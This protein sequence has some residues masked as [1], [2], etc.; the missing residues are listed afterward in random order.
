MPFRQTRVLTHR[1]AVGAAVVVVLAS[2]KLG[3]QSRPALLDKVSVEV[4]AVAESS[5]YLV[6]RYRIV[7]PA[8]N[9]AGVAL[10]SI[11]VSAPRGAG[12]LM[13]PLTGTVERGGS[14]VSDRVPVG[15]IVPERWKAMLGYRAQLKWYAEEAGPVVNDSWIPA[16]ADSVAPGT[17]KDGFGIRSTYLPGFRRFYAEPTLESCCAHPIPGDPE[18]AH[19]SQSAFLVRGITVGPVVHPS[20]VTLALLRSYVQDVCNSRWIAEAAVCM[21]LRTGVEQVISARGRGDTQ[22]AKD[23]LGK[24]IRDL[25]DQHGPGKPVNENAYWLLK[26]N[27]EYLRRQ[28]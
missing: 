12:R 28:L 23:G 2:S 13:L 8:S 20:Q 19:P 21:Q 9:R 5:E 1:L 22:S 3:G 15:V 11:D 10:V 16:N 14:D 6:Y 18:G 7:N 24:L 26:L 27:A 4:T 25:D 17:A